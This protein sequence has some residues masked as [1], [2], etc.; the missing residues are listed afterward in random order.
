MI[1]IITAYSVII[2]FDTCLIHEIKNAIL[3]LFMYATHTCVANLR[4]Y[5]G[6]ALAM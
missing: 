5:L 2:F 3:K 6:F 1:M 4:M